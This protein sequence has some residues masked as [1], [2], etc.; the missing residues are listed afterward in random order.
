MTDAYASEVPS[1]GPE[2]S[3]QV[4]END[5][6]TI[7][8]PADMSPK[9]V[10]DA[11]K[12][13]GRDTKGFRRVDKGAP[14]EDSWSAESLSR[15][16]GLTARTL[17]QS[18]GALA[19][20]PGDLLTGTV[21]NLVG[22]YN[23]K[24]DSK[25][26]APFQNSSSQFLH[27]ALT[28]AGLPEAET[29][30]ERGYDFATGMVMGGGA[31][32]GV[33]NAAKAMRGAMPAGAMAGAPRP[34]SPVLDMLTQNPGG[35]MAG[36][37]A[38]GAAGGYAQSQG[39]GPWTTGGASVLG[40]ML[41]SGWSI[42]LNAARHAAV[43]NASTAEL[44]QTLGNFNRAGTEPTVGQLGNSYT[45]QGAEAMTRRMLGGGGIGNEQ[46]TTQQAAMGRKAQE[47]AE[48]LG[49]GSAY[50]PMQ[51]GAVIENGLD[52]PGGW[53]QRFQAG[54]N[55]LH[56]DPALSNITNVELS[57]TTATLTEL[58][59][60][61]AGAKASTGLLISPT[62]AKFHEAIHEDLAAL[63]MGNGI[64]LPGG[65]IGILDPKTNRI[66]IL[67]AG[68]A[69]P[70]ATALNVDAIRALRT[71]IGQRL[72]SLQLVADFPRVEFNR[73]YGALSRDLEM[74]AMEADMR[75]LGHADPLVTNLVSRWKAGQPI[76]KSEIEA[77]NTVDRNRVNA[78]Q[79][80]LFGPA[81]TA[82]RKANAFSAA[83]HDLI[84]TTLQKFKNEKIPERIW[85][86]AVSGAANKEGSTQL[87]NLFS[88]LRPF[89]Q[90]AVRS[91]VIARLGKAKDGWQDTIDGTMFSSETFLTRWGGI[92]KEARQ[93][94]FGHDPELLADM[95][96]LAETS[97]KIR[98]TM[99][100]D[101]N[102]SGTAG[103]GVR[104]GT[105]MAGAGALMNGNWGV[106]GSIGASVAGAWGVSKVMMQNP[107]FV[108]WLATT[109]RRPTSAMPILLNEAIQLIRESDDPQFKMD[110]AKYI[111]DISDGLRLQAKLEQESPKSTTFLLRDTIKRPA[112]R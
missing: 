41:P 70:A 101:Q 29:P 86:M 67:P 21:N 16:A 107:K 96:A 83:G 20:L 94:L 66:T 75:T 30:A 43:G 1:V 7:R 18:G 87:G 63:G 104:I 80:S 93:I 37:A 53:V 99:R 36:A 6:S 4:W 57:N 84:E 92:S 95:N 74:A 26:P 59:T 58:S 39:A 8:F 46:K 64:P 98:K 79:P 103:A 52:G 13:S 55:V 85:A 89:E 88:A 48:R 73:V 60:P 33:L 19:T 56:R 54:Q 78:G 90:D 111:G 72:E 50:T 3:P 22:A 12:A 23:W 9:D 24:T 110:T 42:P 100:V 10:R 77:I 112:P 91:S 51:A 11:I 69:P 62:L 106:A 81:L 97:A 38:G 40:S 47:V 45:A 109:T 82:Q 65:R 31:Q 44:Q 32:L 102:A 34:P 14:P 27:G 71:R 68:Q 25:V 15:K 28:D 76:A 105:A 61:H 17:I 35:Q 2:P 108:H 49:G 5:T